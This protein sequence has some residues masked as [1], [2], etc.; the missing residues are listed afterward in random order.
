MTVN[1]AARPRPPPLPIWKWLPRA[2][3][4]VVEHSRHRGSRPLHSLVPTSF[5]SYVS[6]YF[7]LLVEESHVVLPGPL[8]AFRPLT[9]AQVIGPA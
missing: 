3:W 2:Q 7:L 8:R 9:F 4:G 1:D 5:P 6:C